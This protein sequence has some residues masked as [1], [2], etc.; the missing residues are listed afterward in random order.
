MK[1][2]NPRPMTP[3]LHQGQRPVAYAAHEVSRPPRSSS[4]G[5]KPTGYGHRA[6]A[7]SQ[8]PIAPPLARTRRPVYLT[9]SVYTRASQAANRPSGCR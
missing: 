1:R 5:Y 6:N 8:Q 7:G 4:G 9:L 2:S 3:G